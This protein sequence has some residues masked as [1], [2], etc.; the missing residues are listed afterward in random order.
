MTIQVVGAVPADEAGKQFSQEAAAPSARQSSRS[1][2]D[3]SQHRAEGLTGCGS[4]AVGVP[5]LCSTSQGLAEQ[6]HFRMLR[7]QPEPPGRAALFRGR[8]AAAACAHALAPLRPGEAARVGPGPEPA[9]A[10]LR[11]APPT[12][13]AHRC[14]HPIEAVAL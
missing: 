13:S 10:D 1:K 4:R 11:P 2:R 6:I 8:T 12:P 14:W 3:T 9:V 5:T 7:L